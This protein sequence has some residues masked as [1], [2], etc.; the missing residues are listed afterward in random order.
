MVVAKPKW[1]IHLTITAQTN[2]IVMAGHSASKTRV[3]ALM[4]D[5]PRLASERKAW[6]PGTRPGM[7]CKMQVR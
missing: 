7:T 4:P 6:M 2:P 5:H 1:T 3:N